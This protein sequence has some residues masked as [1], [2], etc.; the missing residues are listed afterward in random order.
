MNSKVTLKREKLIEKLRHA[1]LL[2]YRK[3]LAEG[4]CT[5]PRSLP[6]AGKIGSPIR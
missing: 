4:R 1:W 5:G 3:G 2:G 6:C